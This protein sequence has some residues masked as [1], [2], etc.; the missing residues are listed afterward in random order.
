MSEHGDCNRD[1]EMTPSDKVR[2]VIV[3]VIIFGWVLVML[4]RR[5]FF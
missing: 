1:P 4:V 3:L 5:V 2:G